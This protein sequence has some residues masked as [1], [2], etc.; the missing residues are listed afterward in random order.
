MPGYSRRSSVRPLACRFCGEP[1][2]ARTV[3]IKGKQVL[4]CGDCAHAAGVGRAD[5][6][7][8][9]GVEDDSAFWRTVD[10]ALAQVEDPRHLLDDFRFAL[11]DRIEALE[12]KMNEDNGVT[13]SMVRVMSR[14][15]RDF[16]RLVETLET[17]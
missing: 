11:E 8:A 12:E 6:R 10:G 16:R 3:R 14:R 9:N 7:K 17:L 5:I 2:L 1:P 13:A 4:A 15:V